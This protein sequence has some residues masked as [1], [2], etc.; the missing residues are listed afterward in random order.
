[1]DGPNNAFASPRLGTLRTA[2]A[3]WAPTK[4]WKD[5]LGHAVPKFVHEDGLRGYLQHGL[6]AVAARPKLPGPVSNISRQGDGY[7]S[8]AAGNPRMK[9][10]T[11]SSLRR[12]TG[13][14]LSPSGRTRVKY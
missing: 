3:D 9:D 12:A 6:L 1:M 10:S 7:R 5:R 14:S 2:A 8:V 13:S 11:G 4:G